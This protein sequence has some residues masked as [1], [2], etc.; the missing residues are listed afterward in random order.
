[1]LLPMQAPIMALKMT[2]PGMAGLAESVRTSQANI[3]KVV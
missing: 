3:R 2:R 1:M